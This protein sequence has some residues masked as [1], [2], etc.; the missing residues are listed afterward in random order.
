M[1]L[2]PV[3]VIWAPLYSYVPRQFFALANG[4]ASVRVG[5]RWVSEQHTGFRP[6]SGANAWCPPYPTWTTEI[7]AQVL[8]PIYNLRDISNLS[9][10]STDPIISPAPT[11]RRRISRI[12]PIS[13]PND[14][15]GRLVSE[16]SLIS[17]MPQRPR[18]A[19]TRPRD[20]F[21]IIHHLHEIG[22]VL[23]DPLAGYVIGLLTGL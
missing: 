14:R 5:G 13:P 22:Y 1:S 7:T 19:N 6:P 15:R 9:H 12:R 8:P 11:P 4:R 23:P 17:T 2:P 3:L 21:A 16:L 20:S 18:L 10:T